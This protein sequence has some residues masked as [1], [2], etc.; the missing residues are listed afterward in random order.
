MYSSLFELRGNFGTVTTHGE[1]DGALVRLTDNALLGGQF[2][3]IADHQFKVLAD[4]KVSG[5]KLYHQ[6]SCQCGDER[7]LPWTR[8]SGLEEM[9]TAL[10]R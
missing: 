6:Y 3:V 4:Q 7:R 5:E 1:G 9:Y 2:R 8:H 10:E